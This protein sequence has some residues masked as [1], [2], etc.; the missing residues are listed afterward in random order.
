MSR[1]VPLAALLTLAGAAPSAQINTGD[2]LPV[3][4]QTFDTASGTRSSLAA[5]AGRAGLVVVF[6]STT[7][8][9]ADRYAPRLAELVDGY[10]SAGFGFVLVDSNG[11]DAL[12][13]PLADSLA[14][15]VLLDPAGEIAGAFGAR[16]AP[17]A[18]LFGPGLTL[19]YDGSIDDSPA[20]AD[21]VR[22]PYLAQ[23]MDQSV[24]GLPIEIQRTQ[25]FGCTTDRGPS[26]VTPTPGT[27]E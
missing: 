10:Q 13:R 12:R 8:P 18:F 19:I 23:A 9:W 21:R 26:R 14:L 7:C 2:P 16:R 5:S 4:G 11:P 20:S 17:H 6:W 3:A 15:P 24:A 25:A 27:P 22:I 1:V